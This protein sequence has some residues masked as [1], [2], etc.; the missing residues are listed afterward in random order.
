MT[1]VTQAELGRAKET[2]LVMHLELRT[3]EFQGL[4]CE[5]FLLVSALALGYY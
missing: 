1:L 2:S 3:S 5:S 4:E